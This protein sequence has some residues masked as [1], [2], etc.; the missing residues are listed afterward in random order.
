AMPETH[1]ARS[2]FTRLAQRRARYLWTAGVD[3]GT[4]LVDRRASQLSVFG[5]FHFL[6]FYDVAIGFRAWWPALFGSGV[7]LGPLQPS[8]AATMPIGFIF[9]RLGA[10]FTLD[11]DRRISVPLHVEVGGSPF[12][13]AQVRLSWGLQVRVTSTL[14]VALKPYTPV[15]TSSVLGEGWNAPTTLEVGWSY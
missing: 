8:Y 10:T 13:A 1:G 7:S 12:P 4:G 3:L 14:S 2:L 15:W 9:G 11:A 5:G 6:H